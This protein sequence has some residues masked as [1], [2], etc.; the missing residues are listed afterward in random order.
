M[1]IRDRRLVMKIE[2]DNDFRGN[3]YIIQNEDVL[4]KFSGGFADLAN[5]IPNTLNTRF[6][7]ASI[8]W[9]I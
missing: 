6:A 7:T 9:T 5:E 1:E 8:Y 2:M 3:A 4:L